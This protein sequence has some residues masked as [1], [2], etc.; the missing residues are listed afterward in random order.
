MLGEHAWRE[1]GLGGSD[2]IDELKQQKTALEQRITDRR[3]QLDERDQ[4]LP[5]PA[6]PT[7]NS[8]HS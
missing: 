8:S 7:G 3:L 2:E 5:S 1:C 4:G 6:R